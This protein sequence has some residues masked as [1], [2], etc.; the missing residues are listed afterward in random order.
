MNYL[1]SQ[2]LFSQYIYLYIYIYLFILNMVGLFL[3]H[4]ERYL[5]SGS[6]QDLAYFRALHLIPLV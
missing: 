3:Y 2:Y 5:G 4:V 6:L 1:F